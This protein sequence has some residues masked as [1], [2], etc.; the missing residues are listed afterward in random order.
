MDLNTVHHLCVTY[1]SWCLYYEYYA[2][3]VYGHIHLEY[4]TPR[5]FIT[6]QPCMHPDVGCSLIRVCMRNAHLGLWTQ[7][8]CITYE[9]CMHPDVYYVLSIML[10]VL[11]EYTLNLWTRQCASLANLACILMSV[12]FWVLCV[13]M[14]V[15][16]YTW[17]CEFEHCTT[18]AKH[19]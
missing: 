17:Y 1:A 8:V 12:V 16:I 11:V 7:A 10:C 9:P 18:V 19:A 4:W 6:C 13:G 14:Y 5:A 2:A 3:C 15:G